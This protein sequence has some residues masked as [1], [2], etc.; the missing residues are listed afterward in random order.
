MLQ[1]AIV[2][3]VVA[4]I[5]VAIV[6]LFN[7]R[8]R[9]KSNPQYLPGDGLFSKLKFWGKT[10]ARGKYGAELQP[11]PSA[12]SLVGRDGR[13]SRDTSRDPSD[14]RRQ[15]DPERNPV[16][17]TETTTNSMA[18]GGVDR[19]TSVRSVM[20]LPAYNPTA[21]ENERVIAREGERGGIDT[22]VEFPENQ[23]DE[24]QRRDNEMESLY[25]IRR[26]RRDEQAERE[27]R[28]R[29]RREARER[30]DQETLRRLQQESR[31]RAENVAQTTSAA[32]IAEHQAAMAARDRR[33]SSVQYAE[34]GVARHDGS[35]I[36]AN[37]TD[38]DNR[39]LLDSA[40]SISGQSLGPSVHSRGMSV[41]SVLSVSTARGSD[42]GDVSPPVDSD[43]FEVVSLEPTYSNT[44][45][46]AGSHHRGSEEAD[47]ADLGI[48][49]PSELPPD[50]D[51]PP[52]YTSP[53][54]T[55]PSVRSILSGPPRLPSLHSIPSIEVTG[56]VSPLSP[57]PNSSGAPLQR[58]ETANSTR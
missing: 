22:V 20:T 8:R 19:N 52:D 40:A 29:V 25:Q 21:R 55:R 26:Q 50:Y 37:S 17:T 30:N 44:R 45:S 57:S 56:A 18:A 58:F 9:S 47:V 54:R 5:A 35:R 15:S 12:P 53:I 23:D 1:A 51:D 34:L 31:A 2:V 4:A 33:V 32:L 39:P 14:R 10:T 7:H 16:E 28:R 41:S 48:Q 27:E 13:R 49:I 3:I 24:E 38:S 6:L 36:R 11:N 46:R 42:G 43:G